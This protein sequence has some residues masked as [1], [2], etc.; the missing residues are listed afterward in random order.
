LG[1]VLRLEHIS[2]ELNRGIPR[3]LWMGKSARVVSLM[4]ANDADAMYLVNSVG[5]SLNLKP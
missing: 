1:F 5:I 4:E 3:I 2:T